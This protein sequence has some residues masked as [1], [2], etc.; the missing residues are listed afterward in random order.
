MKNVK[1]IIMFIV[2]STFVFSSNTRVATLGGNAAFWPEDDA[3]IWVFPHTANNWNIANTDGSDFF[4]MW[5]DN[6]KFG[7]M[8]GLDADMLNMT[9]G[10]NNMGLNFGFGMTP[11][12]DAFAGVACQDGTMDCTEYQAPVVAADATT[13]VKA[14]FGMGLGFGDMGLAFN[15]EGGNMNVGVDFRR[16]QSI[17]IWDNMLLD[18]DFM[19]PE[20]GDPVMELGFDLFTHL[21]IGENTTGLWAM[22]FGWTNAGE[23]G[24]ITF[25]AMTFAVESG[26][27]DWATVRA[28]FTKNWSITNTN[29]MGVMPTF[30]LG[31][32]YGSF[33]LDLNMGNDTGLFTN[34]VEKITGY[35]PLAT[36]TFNI[37]YTW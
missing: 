26:M 8:G 17:W 12:V 3:N 34:P 29:S 9:W 31:F 25:P 22:G 32:N 4:V 28:G 7:F 35:E 21:N 20:T 2:I 14:N 6:M 11:K 15:N 13:T 19:S 1:T 23:N 5:G 33:N 30:G 37:T 18:F 27:T 16:A 24:D 36:G 10:M